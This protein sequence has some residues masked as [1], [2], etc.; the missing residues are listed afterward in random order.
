MNKWSN[1]LL[2]VSLVLAWTSASSS[3]SGTNGGGNGGG[4]GG[5][6]AVG[7]IERQME[8]QQRE[9]KALKL[10]LKKQQRA[11]VQRKALQQQQMQAMAAVA[12]SANANAPRMRQASGKSPLASAAGSGEYVPE[13]GPWTS[14]G[15]QSE[16][17]SC[18]QLRQMWRQS[19]RHA[20]AAE[21]TNEIPQYSD[22]FARAFARQLMAAAAVAASSDGST[23]SGGS[24]EPILRPRPERRPVVYGRL[25]SSPLDEGERTR[26]FDVLRKLQLTAS[27]RDS[28]SDSGA[29]AADT[30]VV[31]YSEDD[32]L[33]SKS[34][35]SSSGLKQL[36]ELYRDGDQGGV[37]GVKG[38]F[39]HL[40]EIV[41]EEKQQQQQRPPA[42]T[43][44]D[45][46]RLVASP[47]SSSASSSSSKYS[48]L[49]NAMQGDAPYE[50]SSSSFHQPASRTGKHLRMGSELNGGG[51][52]G[53]GG[54]RL[55]AFQRTE[56]QRQRAGSSGTGV[57]RLS[58]YSSSSSRPSSVRQRQQQQ[59]QQQL[60]RSDD[61]ATVHRSSAGG[62][63]VKTRRGT[64]IMVS[65]FLLVLL[66]LF[67]LFN[68][69]CRIFSSWRRNNNNNNNNKKKK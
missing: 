11:K 44:T 36:R 29:M 18:E 5:S 41:R 19:K 28:A 35:S 24:M 51:D 13:A 9:L 65:P 4:V 30:G 17:P 57:H 60:A 50:S 42:W 46:G 21:A 34:S 47:S 23:S 39:Q 69:G 64:L 25:Q 6:A 63:Y 66:L 61:F 52:I 67:N 31:L 62:G 59:Q 10:A 3:S 68:P 7:S 22:P 48:T 49:Y 12:A 33:A 40:S 38:R 16:E 27:D 15:A 56:P 53:I 45:V 20:R 54:N 32:K 37:A 55:K 58:G 14:G 43:E 1:W 26:P 8:Q 2:L